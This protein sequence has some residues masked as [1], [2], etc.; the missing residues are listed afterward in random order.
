VDG[1]HVEGVSEHEG[2]ALL[3]AEIREPVPR[4]DAVD[5]DDHVL[6]EGSDD[7]EEVLGVGRAVAVDPDIPLSVEHAHVHVPGV[8]VD[9]AIELVLLRV[10]SHQV[11]SLSSVGG[12]LRGRNL[13]TLPSRQ[14][15]GLDEDQ[16]DAADPCG[17]RLRYH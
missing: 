1:L 10:E 16:V 15:G 9:A 12:L 11:S 8:E 13:L 5:G 17:A 2:N 4:E 6:A 3:P 14:G 7:V